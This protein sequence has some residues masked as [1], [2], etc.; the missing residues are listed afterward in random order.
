MRMGMGM[1][2]LVLLCLIGDLFRRRRVTGP[3]AGELERLLAVEAFLRGRGR[4]RLGGRV[5][6]KGRRKGVVSS[7]QSVQTQRD[8]SAIGEGKDLGL[9]DLMIWHHHLVSGRS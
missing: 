6:G 9:L 4:N 8:V 1:L 5:C 2:V 3:G 7:Q